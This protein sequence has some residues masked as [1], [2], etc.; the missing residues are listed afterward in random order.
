MTVRPR[1]LVVVN[2]EPERLEIVS[3]ASSL[4]KAWDVVFAF[5]GAH[6]LESLATHPYVAVIRGGKILDISPDAFDSE[7]ARTF[8]GVHR[9][10]RTTDLRAPIRKLAEPTAQVLPVSADPADWDHA[11]RRTI[12]VEGWLASASIRSLIGQLRKLPALPAV[13]NQVVAALRDPD[14]PFESIAELIAKDPVMSAKLLQVVNSAYFGLPDPVTSAAGAVMFLGTERVKGL[15]LVAS[16][17]SQFGLSEPCGL[18]L[19]DAW[20]HCL[21]AGAYA[22]AITRWQIKDTRAAEMAFTAGMLHDIGKLLLAANLPADYRRAVELSRAKRLPLFEAEREIFG[23]THAEIGGVTIGTW[24]LPFEMVRAVGLHH[25]L[26]VADDMSFTPLT[27]VHVGDVLAQR[28]TH[29]TNEIPATTFN[30]PYLA[31]IG[32]ESRRGTWRQL[33]GLKPIAGEQTADAR[34]EERM[35]AKQN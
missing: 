16:V 7:V 31:S 24:G 3:K 10:V 27:A 22:Q 19:E 2:G 15:I 21:Q 29:S 13:Y 34:R 20:Q 4:R 26:E 9:L 14:T 11:V 28:A 6:A 5:S 33:C 18:V 32:L 1:L 25:S 8:P 35:S 12:L 30:L 23:V 17:F